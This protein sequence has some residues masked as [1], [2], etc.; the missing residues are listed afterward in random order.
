VTTEDTTSSANSTSTTP[1]QGAPNTSANVAIAT[2]PTVAMVDMLAGFQVSQA[3]YAVAMLDIATL[4]DAGPLPLAELAARAAAHP[5]ALR[6]LV[7]A[8]APMGVFTTDGDTVATTALGATLSRNNPGSAY[9]VARYWVET[10]YQ[11]FTELANTVRTGECGATRFL[12]KPFFDWIVESSDRVEVQNGAFAEITT[13]MRNGTFIDY[14]LPEGDIVADIGGANGSV[15]VTLIKD[16]IDRRGIV[17]DLP[18]IVPAARDL[19]AREGLTDR[20]EIIAGD[21]FA[22]VPAADIYILSY[23]LHD[24]DDESARRILD[25]VATAANPGARLIIVEGVIPPD[26]T[27]HPLR[28]VDLTMLCMLTGREREAGEFVSLLDSGGFTI[29]RIVPTPSPFSIIEATMR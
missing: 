26:D 11:P 22:E 18:E 28:V 2:P 23:I 6:R 17:F 19:I 5:D 15:L 1:L 25:T 27:P 10:H 3:L 29:D 16:E 9:Y 20:I 8:L 12:G 14:S 7:R 21:F 4:L 24:W 13:G